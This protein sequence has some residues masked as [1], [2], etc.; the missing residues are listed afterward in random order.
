MPGRIDIAF[1]L[2]FAVVIAGFAAFYF[3]RRFKAQVAAGVPD[4]RMRAYRRA[5]IGQWTAS[6]VAL[7]L[8]VRAG[9][10]WAALG[11]AP[12]HDRH[13]YFAVGFFV[14]LAAIGT[15]QV[16]SIRRL[17]PESSAAV[18]KKFADLEFL[19][20]HTR[21]EYRLFIVL[22]ITAGICEELLYRGYLTWLL[23]AYVGLPL[24]I[25]L[26]VIAFGLAHGYQG[27]SGVVK[28]GLVGLVM[29]LIVVGTGWL[30]PAML[31][32]ALID[33]SS[34]YIGYT[35]LNQP[36]DAGVSPSA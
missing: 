1:A 27:M 12:A 20:P 33:L 10:S 36:A 25:T 3:D 5:V 15:V 22:A 28:T 4:A 35:V 32:H 14:G 8:W 7:V 23:A 21:T 13:W 30:V 18:R 6:I 24:S 19:L 11:I 34:G 17:T 2:L 31:L 9:R 16:R 29:S 26:V